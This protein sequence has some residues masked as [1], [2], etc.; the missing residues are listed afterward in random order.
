M[1]HVTTRRHF[2]KQTSA[3]AAAGLL[4]LRWPRLDGAGQLD[5]IG[6]QLYSVRDLFLADMA[7]T[8]R[9]LRDIGYDEVEL[10]GWGT[11]TVSEVKTAFSKSGMHCPS[12]HIPLDQLRENLS[13]VIGQAKF[14]KLNYIVC[15]YIDEE[16]RTVAGYRQVA[17]MLNQAGYVAEQSDIIVAYHN[18]AYDFADLNG[19]RGFDI[20]LEETDS[21]VVKLELD[22]YWIR[23]GGGDPL[24]YL[25]K[26]HGRY[27]M[28]HIKDMAA[29]GSMTDVGAGV[30]EW[31]PILA[32]AEQ[33]GV[34]H[35]FVEHDQPADPMGFAQ[36]SF[37]WLERLH[38]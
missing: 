3:L 8:L 31:K 30:I 4:P 35:Y 24:A 29:D 15:P 10:A 16:F 32:A 38:W 14:L 22:I 21:K 28:M 20:L 9:Q 7:G 11:H 12:A 25:A 23:Q 26:H 1:K 36:S 27:H 5:R 34:K 19:K 2:L 18:Q 37:T 6:I 17:A 33:A 13:E